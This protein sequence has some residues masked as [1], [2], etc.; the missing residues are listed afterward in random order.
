MNYFEEVFFANVYFPINSLKL[1]RSNIMCIFFASCHTSAITGILYMLLML[2]L[3]GEQLS[4]YP[5]RTITTC[6]E[7]I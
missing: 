1:Y 6:V 2:L 7:Y 5:P 3:V 4:K